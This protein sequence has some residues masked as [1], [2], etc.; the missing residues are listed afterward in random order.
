VL[1]NQAVR[2]ILTSSEFSDL[3]LFVEIGPH[4]AMS[5]PFKQIKA[6]VGPDGKV[7]YLPTLLRGK[8]SAV[9][10]LS[11]VGEMFHRSYPVVAERVASIYTESPSRSST[12][13]CA[14]CRSRKPW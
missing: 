1:F 10:L 11:F 5:G 9:Q 13:R 4:S 7:D 3:D 2:T 8:D 14:T 12:M 6:T